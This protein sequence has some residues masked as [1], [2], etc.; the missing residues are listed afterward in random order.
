METAKR[1]ALLR[2]GLGVGELPAAELAADE[3]NQ[4]PVFAPVV[5]TETVAPAK[6]APNPSPVSRQLAA[7]IRQE[8]SAAAPVGS[9]GTG[10]ESTAS[11]SDTLQLEKMTVNGKRLLA[12]VLRETAVEKFTRTGH[13][14]E[15]SR[16]KRLMIGPKGDKVGV[17]F[18]FDW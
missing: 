15:F 5:V 9:A 12:P 6:S 17:M 13:L 3:R 8:I 14:W 2:V 10:H 16:T 18:S 4:S 7:L 1:L 11:G